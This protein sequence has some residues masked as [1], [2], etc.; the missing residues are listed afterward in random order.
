MTAFTLKAPL[1]T[2]QQECE[3]LFQWAHVTKFQGTRLSE[4]LI[5]IPNGAYLG[6]DARQRAITMAKLKR[7]GFKAGVFDY[8]LPIP[9]RPLL[10]PGLWVEMKRQKLGVV[11]DDQLKFM[12]LMQRLGWMTTICKGFDHAQQSITKYLSQCVT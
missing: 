2:E 9:S 4:L 7:S 11:S 12:T 5:M 10:S 6:A 3:L 8:L 1:P